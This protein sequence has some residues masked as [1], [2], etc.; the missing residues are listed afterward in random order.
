MTTLAKRVLNF[1][2]DLDPEFNFIFFEG[3][4]M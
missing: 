3:V 2:V 1:K 4:R